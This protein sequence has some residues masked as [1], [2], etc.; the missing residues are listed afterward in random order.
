M[1]FSRFVHNP[2]KV[3]MFFVALVLMGTL[4]Y[5]RLALNLFPDL[6]TPRITVIATTRGLTPAEAE[7]RVSEDLERGL[8][9]IEGVSNVTTYTRER[10]IVV[11]VDFHWGSDMEFAYLDVKKSVGT[12]ETRENVE[13]I[14]VFRFDPNAAPLMTLAFTGR[15]NRVQLTNLIENSLRPKFETVEGVAYVNANG[16]SHQ[17][18]LVFVNED[19]MA[20]YNLTPENIL[21]QIK[22]NNI[23]Q[24]AGFVIEGNQEMALK[25]VS[26]FKNVDEIANSV[27]AMMEDHPIRLRDVGEVVL[28]RTIDEVIVRQDG[29]ESITLD[30]IKEPDANAV[31]TARRVRE[32]VDQ[33][34]ARGLYGM[35]IAADQS[36]EVE[37][38]IGAVIQT[39][40]IGMG[41]ATIVLMIFLR[42]FLATMVVALAIPISII[43]TFSP[44]YFQGLS[45]NIMTLGG[46]AL[47][48]GMLVDN[49]IVVMENIFRHR[50][51]GLASVEAAVLGAREV[52]MAITAATLT[53][54]VVFVPL[55]Y[56][57]GI[58]GIL[59]KDQAMTVVYSLL[60]SLLVAL[61]LIPMLTARL[62]HGREKPPGPINRAY[63]GFLRRSLRLRWAIVPVFV[64]IMWLSWIG[65]QSIPQEFF[66]QAVNGR[67][68]MQLEMPPGTP[69]YRTTEAVRR[70]EQAL[71][72]PRVRYHGDPDLLPLLQVFE[73]WEIHGD[74]EKFI[75]EAGAA[76][77]MLKT[78]HP[79]PARIDRLRQLLPASQDRA[80]SVA[81]LAEISKK[82]ATFADNLIPLIVVRSITSTIGVDPESIE[83]VSD[84]IVG[85]NT[86][87]LEVVL[88]PLLLR[89]FAAEDA[90]EFLRAEA[91]AIPELKISFDSRNEYLQHLLG[92]SRGDIVLEVH[93]E[94]METLREAADRVA[95]ELDAMDGIINV[96][97]NLVVGGDEIILEPD[98]DALLRH[99]YKIEEIAQQVQS[100][101]Q[102][103]TSDRLRLEQGEMAISITNL[104]AREEGLEGLLNLPIVAEAGAVEKLRDLATI[105]LEGGILEIMRVNQ[106]KTLLVTADLDGIA[107][108]TAV[109]AVQARL[110]A[111]DWP[112]GATWNMS[113]EEVQRRESFQRLFFA[114]TI[115]L[116]LVYM[117][118]ASILESLIHPFT[119]MF[120]V[121]FALAGVVG[122]FLLLGINLN[123]MAYIGIVM[124]VG[125]V[126]N[127]AI[128]LLDR[129]QQLRLA[130]TETREAV[131]LAARQRLRPIVMTS[132]TTILALTPL[133]LGFGNGAELRRPMAIAVIG[134]LASSIESTVTGPTPEATET[135]NT[136]ANATKTPIAMF[137][138]LP[139]IIQTSF[140]D[141]SAPHR[142]DR[143]VC[144]EQL[145]AAQYHCA[146]SE[147]PRTRDQ[148]SNLH[149]GSLSGVCGMPPCYPHRRLFM[150]CHRRGG[151]SVV[152]LNSATI[153]GR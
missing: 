51:R 77:A 99:Q 79:D 28:G 143:I 126:V 91:E 24:S 57:H 114:L 106:E 110:D 108:Q 65:L 20:Q 27:I 52:A 95:A 49:A 138:L 107:Y 113:R 141:Y 70:L 89:E 98:R 60:M 150:P 55:V 23:S 153:S 61:A 6:R 124:L 125:I 148:P 147:R 123:L 96:A 83:A 54:V 112:G 94:D 59:F 118:I 101:L 80:L 26:R 42:S 129:I 63:G 17:E 41:L 131:V 29:R 127:N 130:G 73:A 142:Y 121:P 92:G 71:L 32:V 137:L 119:I 128:V 62:P 145:Q 22:N 43:A 1:S 12:L 38:A 67:F 144:L 45:L 36:I 84:E 37:A 122:L 8:V 7:R 93:A 16:L 135:A 82:L 13:K 152:Y 87:R 140:L 4:S 115:A 46:L 117:V 58:A 39:A 69:L 15:V 9:S 88:N 78:T 120:S 10:N 81:E 111:M 64:G 2:V 68:S 25:F 47:G 75:E 105:R 18:V 136:R 149:G 74:D 104:R 72:Q 90:A 133:S 30:I 11:H 19:I 66:P 3:T 48:A 44:M 86:A 50:Q 109:Q 31:L 14:D 56:V 5:R 35:K 53:T 34:N 97:T 139:S 151:V 132:L 40:A 134:G 100:Y 116:V 76:L 102:G 33:L 21:E 85:A 146:S 103:S